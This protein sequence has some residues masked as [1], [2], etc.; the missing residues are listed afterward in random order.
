MKILIIYDHPEY[1]CREILEVCKNQGIEVVVKKARNPGLREIVC[2][3]NKYDGII[4]DMG[5]PIYEG[6]RDI[7][8][9]V[10]DEIL[11]E[12]RRKKLSIPVLIFSETESKY[13]NR[14]DFVFDQ[15][16]SS[17]VVQEEE[18]FYAF[19]EKLAEKN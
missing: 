17:N 3:G 19:L 11:A 12:L 5:L 16:S 8:E 14:C 9:R 15:M 2:S 7:G 6:G 10:G 1:K 4:L 13:K 18:K